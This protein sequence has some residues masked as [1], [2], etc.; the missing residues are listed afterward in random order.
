MLAK[1]LSD[2]ARIIINDDDEDEEGSS[3]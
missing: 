1:K 2:E 3:I